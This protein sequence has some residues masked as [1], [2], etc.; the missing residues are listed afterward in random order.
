SL[1]HLKNSLSFLVMLSN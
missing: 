1:Y